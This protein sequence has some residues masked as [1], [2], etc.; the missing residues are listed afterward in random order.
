MLAWC[1][2]CSKVQVEIC[3]EEG[4]KFFNG[5]DVRELRDEINICIVI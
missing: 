3:D 4:V 1:A 2:G 5:K